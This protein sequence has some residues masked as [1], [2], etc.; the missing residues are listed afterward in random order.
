MSDK[1]ESG[2][3]ECEAII[4]FNLKKRLTLVEGDMLA[5]HFMALTGGTVEII[6][7][8]DGGSGKL[9]ISCGTIFVDDGK[10][11]GQRKGR[12]AAAAMALFSERLTGI[13][14][15]ISPSNCLEQRV[16]G[17]DHVPPPNP[18]QP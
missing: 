5:V 3:R 15:P 4:E 11:L 16:S 9:K 7:P 10:P 8:K 2:I 12:C 17:T 18:V 14:R 6:Q 13:E 1:R